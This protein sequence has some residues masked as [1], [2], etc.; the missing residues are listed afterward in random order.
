MP[1]LTKQLILDLQ[2]GP[3]AYKVSDEVIPGKSAKTQGVSGLLVRVCAGGAKTF[4]VQYRTKDGRKG[5]YPLG[6]FGILTLDQARDKASKLLLAVAN[7]EDPGRKL[8]ED[9]DAMTV[10]ELVE[11]FITDHAATKA[12]RTHR[13][14]ARLM[15]QFVA[16][17]IGSRKVQS[18]GTSDMADLL[19]SIRK[20]TPTQ[21]NRVLAVARKMFNLA[22]LWEVRAPGTNPVIGQVRTTETARERRM[23]EAEVRAVGKM[24]QEVRAL[25]VAGEVDGATLQPESVHALA[26]IQLALLAGF[27][28]GEVLGLR[29]S[30]VDLDK[31]VAVLP[32]TA[33]KTGRKTGKSRV[34]YLCP[35]A[36]A[37]LRALPRFDE[38]PEAKGYNPHVI[39]GHRKGAQL[40]QVQNTWERLRDA[41]TARSKHEASKQHKKKPQIVTITDVTIHDLR[42]T[43][44]SVAADLGHPE[45]IIKALLGHQSLGSVTE[46][47][48]RLSVDPIRAAVNEVGGMIAVWLG[49]DQAP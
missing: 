3:K 9:R 16:G 23:S 36:V 4:A 11:K 37:L 31:G 6:R 48:T 19:S 22:E 10:S 1:Y 21:A 34:V 20:E 28:K 30:W 25:E 45:L 35:E 40:V 39:V 42:R 47:Y 15:R 33:H 17:K 29:W 27:R 5:W 46:V 32:A 24:I 8:R 7:G 18:I 43:F 13:E 26:A 12:D 44:A 49:L 2:P 38:D 41:V 14:Y